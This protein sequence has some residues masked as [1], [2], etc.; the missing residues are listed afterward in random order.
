M[1]DSPVLND[2]RLVKTKEGFYQVADLPSNQ[3]LT[4]YYAG[5]YYQTNRGS[6]RAEYSQREREYFDIL[7]ARDA[8]LVAKIR[9]NKPGT[10]LDVGCGEGFALSWFDR[11][12][13]TVEGL[14]FSSAG[15]AAMNPH[16][17]DKADQGDVFALLA[18]RIAAG[19]TYD[20]VWLTNVLEHV[21]DPPGLLESLGKLVSPGGVLL[22]TVPND[23]SAFQEM[24][25]E[26][27]RIDER[28][29]VAIPDHLAYFTSDSLRTIAAATGWTCHDIIA[30]FP[31]DLFLLH[32]GSNYIRDKEAGPIAHQARIE[33]EHLLSHRP[34]EDVHAFLTAMATVGLGRTLTAAFTRVGDSQ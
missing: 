30:G 19:R 34:A 3:E 18:A 16:M 25:L 21:I 8:H 33:M 4:D 27:G 23:G 2:P 6:Y 31:V 22:L 1:T 17:A 20:L 7:I 10:M 26:T 12:G 24:L 15:I 29:W 28:F 32:S 11:H 14:D 9:G 5:L 13:W